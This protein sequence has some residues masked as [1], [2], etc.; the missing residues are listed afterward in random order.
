MPN[1]SDFNL[2]N[3][4]HY[5]R[6]LVLKT[7][8]MEILVV[9][10]Q[11]GQGTAFHGHGPT[12]G[13]VTVLQGQMQNTAIFSPEHPS[14]GRHITTLHNAGDICHSPVG[15]QHRMLNISPDPAITLHFYAPPLGDE[16]LNPDLGYA[17]HIETQEVQLSDAAIRIVMASSITQKALTDLCYS[18]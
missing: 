5:S 13:V 9:C 1:L 11:P 8:N 18:I 4:N 6:H 17:N 10:W 7:P 16:Y 2:F 3:D 12:D 14:G 15:S